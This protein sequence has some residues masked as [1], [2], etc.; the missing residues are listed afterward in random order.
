[1]SFI[2]PENFRGLIKY[3]FALKVVHQEAEHPGEAEQTP[4]ENEVIL[5]MSGK[6]HAA[7]VGP[8]MIMK[9]FGGAH[10]VNGFQNGVMMIMMILQ[11]LAL[12]ILQEHLCL[13]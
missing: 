2:I 4:I 6:Q 12:L 3:C 5:M 13:R 1:M 10:P 11:H 9:T 8:I 7:V